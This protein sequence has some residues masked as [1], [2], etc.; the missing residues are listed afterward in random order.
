MT[1]KA[2][3]SPRNF[4]KYMQRLQT[5]VCSRTRTDRDLPLSFTKIT[6]GP[7]KIPGVQST[8]GSVEN[9]CLGGLATE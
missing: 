4:Q 5:R 6:K 9:S 1:D 3:R 8:E 7:S 2:W